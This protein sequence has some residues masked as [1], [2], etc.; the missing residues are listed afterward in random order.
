MATIASAHS[1]KSTETGISAS[2]AV[3]ADDTSNPGRPEN[4]FSAVGLRRQFCVQINNTFI[5]ETSAGWTRPLN[6]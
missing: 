6:D 2:I 3:P 5:V 4:T 1:I